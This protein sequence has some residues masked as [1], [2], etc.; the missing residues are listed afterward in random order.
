MLAAATATPAFARKSTSVLDEHDALGLAGLVKKKQVSP[1]E[2]LDLAIARTEALNP[3]Y[4]FLSQNHFDLARTAVAKGV[5]DGPF[6]GVPWLIKDL[7]TYIAGQI[8][9]NGSCL[10]RDFRPNYTSELVK[11]HERA[12]LVIFGKTTT[13]EFGLTGT[14]ESVVTGATHNPWNIEHSAGGSSGGAAVAVALGIIPAAHATDGG[15]S[16]RIPASACGLFGLK[17]S[18]GVFR[19]DRRARKAGA[20]CPATMRLRARCATA[21]RCSTQRTGRNLARGIARPRR[22][23]RILKK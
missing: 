9:Q 11:R 6:A 2:L 10:Y 21:P 1:K 3:R 5:P 16:I 23:D 15:G 8:T 18:R 12:G 4:N 7:N 19:W 22:S 14:T 17:P 13:P 20:D